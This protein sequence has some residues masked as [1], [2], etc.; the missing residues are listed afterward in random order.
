[1]EPGAYGGHYLLDSAFNAYMIQTN[2][3]EMLTLYGGSPSSGAW[4]IVRGAAIAAGAGR[5]AVSWA[6]ASPVTRSGCAD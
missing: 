3:D 2:S 6:M 5:R 1:M 4:R